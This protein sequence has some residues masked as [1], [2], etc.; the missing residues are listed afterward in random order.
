MRAHMNK[1]FVIGMRGI[2]SDRFL[3][4]Q[5]NA[6]FGAAVELAIFPYG[7]NFGTDATVARFSATT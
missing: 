5:V 1:M 7:T 6:D 4:L 2:G 3:F